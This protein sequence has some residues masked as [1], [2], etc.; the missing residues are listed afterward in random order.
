MNWDAL[1]AV[2]EL[3]GAIAVVITLVYLAVQVRQSNSAAK[4]S[5]AATVLMN[6]QNVAHAL[7]LDRQLREIVLR[8]LAGEGKLSSADKL[9]A[10]AWFH[11]LLKTGELAYMSFLH[12]ELDQEYWEGWLNFY[13]SYYQTPGLQAYWA[14]RKGAFTPAFQASVEKWM[15]ESTI[16]VTRAD[17]LFS[18]DS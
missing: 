5:N 7:T 6:S 17:K 2:G 3:V 8:A 14:E 18:A 1:G 16:P 15:E 9:A 10:Y 11:Q 13:R 4:S 12:G